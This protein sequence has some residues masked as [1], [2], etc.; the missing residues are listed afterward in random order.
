MTKV[1]IAQATNKTAAALYEFVKKV[2]SRT[3]IKAYPSVDNMATFF[4]TDRH[5][6]NFICSLLDEKGYTY[7]IEN[8]L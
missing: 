6:K 5:D 7:T 1:I 3:A 8:A 2:A 4:V